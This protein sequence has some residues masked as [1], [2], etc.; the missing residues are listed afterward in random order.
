MKFFNS[1]RVEELK[2]FIF[3]IYFFGSLFLAFLSLYGLF[4]GVGV[5]ATACGVLYLLTASCFVLSR[6]FRNNSLS[7]IVCVFNFCF[8]HIPTFFVLAMGINYKYAEGLTFLR[9]VPDFI[10]NLPLSFLMLT[11]CSISIW[12]GLICQ[13]NQTKKTT[14][15]FLSKVRLEAILIIA[16][17]VAIISISESKSYFDAYKFSQAKQE[18]FLAFIFFDLAFQYLAPLFLFLMFNNQLRSNKSKS[19]I[20][21]A[22]ILLSA[23]YMILSFFSTS[24]A[25]PLNI[26]MAFIILPCSISYKSSNLRI[27]APTKFFFY[28][29]IILLPLIFYILESKR[30]SIASNDNLA[31]ADYFR[32]LSNNF[33]DIFLNTVDHILY[34]ISWQGLDR[35]LIILN[36]YL[37]PN[38]NASLDFLSYVTKNF[39]NLILPGTIFPEAYAPSSQI[40][41]QVVDKSIDTYSVI[42]PASLIKRLN[43]QPY[44]IYGVFIIIF[45]FL[46]PFFLFLFSYLCSYIYNTISGA[47]F[48]LATLQFFWATTASF[49]PEV[50]LANTAHF[51]LSIIILTYTMNFISYLFYPKPLGGRRN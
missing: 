28:L 39:F 12:L 4:S 50:V 42:D 35:F 17:V 38:L 37:I 5:L 25:G 19:F 31:I 41:S 45:G 46:A 18:S 23:M 34:R 33:L 10:H 8:F 49:G 24:K 44:T 29:L 7:L 2:N 15:T 13:N 47:L 22:I 14:L 51:L 9:I 11:L 16:I 43:T 21:A 1:Y 48:R 6:P 40:F 36:T 20:S 3:K 32:A 26:I 30:I 27:L